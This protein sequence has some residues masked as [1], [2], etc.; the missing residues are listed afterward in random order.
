MRT[1][2]M[3]FPFDVRV[4]HID[5]Y[6]L[7]APYTTRTLAIPPGGRTDVEVALTG[8]TS[9]TYTITND[10]QA[11][12]AI[13]AHYTGNDAPAAAS[14]FPAAPAHPVDAALVARAPDFTLD[15]GEAMGSMMGQAG[16]MM[17][18]TINGQVYPDTG[19]FDVA[20]GQAYKVRFTNQGMERIAH[21]M[22]IHGAHFQVVAVDSQPTND[23]TWYDT[24]SVPYGGY[25][26]IAITF[27]QPGEWMVHCHILDHEDGGMMASFTVS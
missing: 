10:R 4:T 13:P 26:D 24:S 9:T 5:G 1:Q 8:V 21:P 20:R 6:P 19:T 25:V 15:L 3:S 18:W 7:S 16:S 14:G 23:D 12:M 11:G 2:A 17:R 27:T 22:H